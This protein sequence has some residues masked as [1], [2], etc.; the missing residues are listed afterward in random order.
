MTEPL[1]CP[2]CHRR[3]QTR[4]GGWPS[5]SCPACGAPMILARE[6]AQALVRRYMHGDRLAPQPRPGGRAPG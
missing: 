6:Q 2:R 5:R 1:E 3:A 4:G